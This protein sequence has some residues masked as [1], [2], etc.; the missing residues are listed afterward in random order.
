MYVLCDYPTNEI[1]LFLSLDKLQSE[2]L[3]PFI[4]SKPFTFQLLQH[5]TYYL[6]IFVQQQ[7]NENPMLYLDNNIY[8][9]DTR[10]KNK[11]KSSAFVSFHSQH[12]YAK[13]DY[14]AYL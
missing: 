6:V 9:L 12:Q 13:S 4:A 7:L 11:K 5:F 10:K 2:M 14:A 3:T 1:N 8:S